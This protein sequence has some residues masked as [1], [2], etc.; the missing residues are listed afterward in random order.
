MHANLRTDRT[1]A[2]IDGR[3]NLGADPMLLT[4]VRGREALSELFR[5]EFDILWQDLTKP[6][7]FDKL[8]GQ[9]VTASFEHRAGKRY[10]NGIVSRITQ[11]ERA[12]QFTQYRLEVVPQLWLLTRNHQSRIFQHLTVPDILKK[13]LDGLDVTLRDPG[14]RSRRANTVSS[15]ARPISISPAG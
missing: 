8:L 1:A 15:T 3:P 6:L 4:A 12:G 5:F 11:G 13:V 10:F 9:K 2:A 7:P 14:R